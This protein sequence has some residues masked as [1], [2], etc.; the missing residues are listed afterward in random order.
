MW[1]MHPSPTRHVRSHV[2]IDRLQRGRRSIFDDGADRLITHDLASPQRSAQ[3]D[4][5]GLMYLPSTYDVESQEIAPGEGG[6]G[7]ALLC[8]AVACACRQKGLAHVILA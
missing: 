5:P 1:W 3:H 4:D 7:R 8:S 2:W 6:R